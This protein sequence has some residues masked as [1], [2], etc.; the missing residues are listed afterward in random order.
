MRFVQGTSIA[1]QVGVANGQPSATPQPWSLKS[2]I[3]VIVLSR[4]YRLSSHSSSAAERLDSANELY[5]RMN[6]RRLEVEALRDSMLSVAGRLTFDRPDGIQVAGTGGKGR[7]GV[8]RS[9]LDIDAPCRTVYLPV[10]RSLVPEMYS[11][12]DFPDP[13]QINGR[14]DVTT[15]APQTLFLMN[16]DFSARTASAT[17]ERV[18]ADV[19]DNEERVRVLY[20][21]LLGRLPDRNEI[22]G[23]LDFLNQLSANTSERSRWATLTQALMICG[24][25]RTLL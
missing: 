5:W 25:F 6:M 23:A 18:L 7:W 12:F 16:S 22:R 13:N 8:T 3:R 9:L 2:L 11:T 17:A 14:R 19:R 4:T 15:V 24:E 1:H 21:R 10:L 20:L